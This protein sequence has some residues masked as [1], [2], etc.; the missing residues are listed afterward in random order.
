M[1][2]V[3][4]YVYKGLR[5]PKFSPDFALYDFIDTQTKI[6]YIVYIVSGSI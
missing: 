3:G 6:K 4:D 5:S 2:Q 1:P